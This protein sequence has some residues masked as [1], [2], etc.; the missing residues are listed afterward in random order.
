M[1][2]RK[3]IY[4]QQLVEALAQGVLIIDKKGVIH[5]A[6]EQAASLFGLVPDKLIGTY[7]TQPLNTQE[8]QEIEIFKQNGGIRIAQMVVRPGAWQG[9]FAWIVSLLDI[10]ELKEK[11]KLLAI[12]SKSV[13]SASEGIIITDENG[14][15][16]QANKAFLELTGFKEREV[17]GKNP[18]LL[19]SGN[20]T[21]GFYENLWN[22]LIR[23]GYWSGEIVN[24]DKN[25]QISILL[26]LSAVKD[27]NGEISNYIGFFH[28]LTILKAQERQLERAKYYDVVTALPNKFF[29]T[30]NLEQYIRNSHH[31]N[32]N[33]IIQSIRIFG[34]HKD[35]IYAENQQT[36]D[37][38]I[39]Q[40][41][42]RIRRTT[43]KVQFLARIGYNEFI[44]VYFTHQNLAS[45][46]SV[47]KQIIKVLTKP[48]K[49]NEKSYKI[50]CVIG[51]ATYKK[52]SAFSA[53]ELLHQA[54]IARHKARLLGVNTFDFFDPQ[55]EIDTIEFNK[56]IK[57][58][59]QAIQANQLE[60]YY[61]PKVNL[62]TGKVI[63]LEALLR[64]NHP[65]RGLLTASEFLF[66]IDYH[67]ISLELG[68]WVI[69][70][71]LRQAEIL[72][73]QHLEIPISINISSYQLQDKDFVKKI[74]EALASYPTVP[75]K[76]LMLE[77]LETE[78][79][80]DLQ[81]VSRIIRDCRERDILFSLDDF[82]TGYSSLTYLKEL[83]IAEVKLDQS[84]IRN[85]LKK[86]KDLA[87]LKSTI[88][89]CRIMG[90]ELVAEGV[91]TVLHGKLLM[92]LGCNHVQGFAISKALSSNALIPWL[93]NWSLGAEWR[94][95]ELTNELIDKFIYIA[96]EHYMQFQKIGQYLKNEQVSLP[97][98][99]L[100]NCLL[101]KMLH[102]Y[103][104][105]LAS[106]AFDKLNTYHKK[107]HL[108]AK[109]IIQLAKSNNHEEAYKQLEQF[110]KIRNLMLRNLILAIFKPD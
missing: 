76:L 27:E 5:Y 64:W 86:P 105:K 2:N 24:K 100:K 62:K 50:Y 29:L 21:R 94:Y 14:T 44:I 47:A 107:Q 57:S 93:K 13:Q 46:S 102:K 45:F 10:S 55:V 67:P 19:H 33:L 37:K 25:K 49:V 52:Y 12:T 23:Q 79:L 11:D 92:H 34:S 90:H 110:E 30:K 103:A 17:L 42:E 1:I 108:L 18:N 99:N 41:V 8:V 16:I 81:L 59:H 85:I 54:E 66:Q 69:H 74:D 104:S 82:G 84:F 26:T 109:K 22:V 98:L 70:Q 83:D 75:S 72:T 77:I 3:E 71:A 31:K 78:A 36:R 6:N 63:G 89:L 60:L 40:V 91:E 20:Q 56:Y 32:K 7:F 35:S 38:I 51:L 87:I 73:A 4:W 101:D 53:E 97:D 61:Q 15:I 95:D 80:A 28:D 39:L 43:H 48:Y 9:Q 68:H 96:V 58:I 88:D 106:E 65:K